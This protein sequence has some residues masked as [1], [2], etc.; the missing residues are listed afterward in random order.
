MN[1][2]ELSRIEH[3]RQF[4]KQIRGNDS[5]LIIGID[6]AKDKH[7][8]FFGTANGRVI[9]RVLI[10]ENS[11]QGFEKLLTRVQ[12]YMDRDGFG[13]V[14]FGLE[15]TSV[16]HKPLAEHLIKNQ[17][18]VV[19][20]TNEAINKNR[21]LLDGRWDKNDTKDAANVADLLSQA[22][23]HY[24]DLPDIR[25][26]DIR[27]L[28][29]LRKR[30][31][32][33]L[34]SSRMRIR[35]N[36]VAQYFPEMDNLWKQVETENLSIVRWCLAPEKIKQLEYDAFFKTVTSHKKGLRQSRRLRQI[37]ELANESIGCQ[38]GSAVS[39]EARLL[40]N[41]VLI[42][43]EQ[44]DEVDKMIERLCRYYE[45]YELLQT[46][47]GFGP[48]VSAVVLAA[49]G[50]P[51][52]FENVRQLKRLAGYDLNAKRS[53]KRSAQAVPVIS[54]KGKADLRYALYQAALV[55]SSLTVPFRAYYHRILEGRQREKGIRTKMRVKLAAKML[56]IAWTMM[57]HKV[58]F[59]PSHL[60][61]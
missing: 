13:Q 3:F 37:W 30:L 6:I 48:Y 11:A 23:C 18:L 8:A 20:V 28:L 54:K 7:R 12:F 55:A 32:K 31:K 40:V 59:D 57:K 2:K 44:I 35:N 24:Y 15:P 22:K 1:I 56:V 60:R 27:S 33:Q 50:N 61:C 58:Q 49:I 53:G 14:A 34:H 52:R 51:H 39:L 36:L 21:S 10:F 26:R 4:K 19:Y 17:Y 47:P 9:L 43:K 5:Y 25:L 16:Y 46:I 41:S 38:V 45:E 29:L 42:I